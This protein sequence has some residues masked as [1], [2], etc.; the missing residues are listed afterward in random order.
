MNITTTTVHTLH[1]DALPTGSVELKYLPLEYITPVVKNYDDG[2]FVVVYALHDNYPDFDLDY[3]L[4]EGV[5]FEEFR[6]QDERDK[7]YNETDPETHVAFIVDH[8]EHSAHH[9]S[10]HG[11]QAYPYG[12]WDTRP[13]CVLRVPVDFVDPEEA[14]ESMLE[15]YTALVNGD[16]YLIVRQEY[17]AAGNLKEA[18]YPVGG[19]YGLKHAEAA[20]A[21]DNY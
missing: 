3:V 13:S 8:F 14:A 9:Y 7:F 21:E 16:T 5:E 17:D 18:P 19:F 1:D 10:L 4:G 12:G 11:S 20:V 6:T 2:S 15:A